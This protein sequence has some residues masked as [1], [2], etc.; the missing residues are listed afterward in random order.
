MLS[1]SLRE[2]EVTWIPEGIDVASYY[3]MPYTQKDIDVLAFGTR[4]SP[5]HNLILKPITAAGLRYEY[6]TDP[7]TLLFPT[8]QSFIQGLA[9]AKISICFPGNLRDLVRTGDIETMTL[10]YLQSMISKCLIV[11]HA[12]AEMKQLFSYNPIIEADMNSPA[13]QLIDILENYDTYIPLIERNFVSVVQNHSWDV[14]WHTI[15]KL[16]LT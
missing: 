16:L 11:G 4:Y 6:Q 1:S 15:A 8:R 7:N 5:Y 9:H 2:C 13:D 12:P 14:R 3:Y 10:R